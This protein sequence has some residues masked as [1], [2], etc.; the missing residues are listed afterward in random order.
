M[1]FIAPIGTFEHVTAKAGGGRA[2]ATPIKAF[3]TR[4]AVCATSGDSV[5][6]PEAL[7]GTPY[8]LIHDGGAPTRVFATGNDTID[9]IAGATGV[10]LSNSKRCL[11]LCIAQGMWISAQ[12]GAVAS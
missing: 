7:S 5:C 6:L 8:L 3:C 12:L 1:D 4:L 9:G 10:V 2:R 11:F